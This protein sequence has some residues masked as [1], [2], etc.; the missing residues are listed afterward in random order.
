MKSKQILIY[1]DLEINTDKKILLDTFKDEIENYLKIN[2]CN[3]AEKIEN[4]PESIQK[5]I[6]RTF[7]FK[8]EIDTRLQQLNIST[9]DLEKINKFIE[10]YNQT[11]RLILKMCK[12]QN[13]KG[14]II[15]EVFKKNIWR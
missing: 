2:K 5:L 11:Q 4:Y 9:K 15:E 3:A 14:I 12:R 7:Y 10:A 13:I 1:K 8:S 6:W